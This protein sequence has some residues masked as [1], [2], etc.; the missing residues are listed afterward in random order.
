MKK[1][2]SRNDSWRGHKYLYGIPPQECERAEIIRES[3]KADSHVKIIQNGVITYD[4][5]TRGNGIGVFSR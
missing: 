4:S 1:P 3:G 5:R 2:H